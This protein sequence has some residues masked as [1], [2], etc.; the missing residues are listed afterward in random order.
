MK[1]YGLRSVHLY[2]NKEDLCRAVEEHF[3]AQVGGGTSFGEGRW[4]VAWA[5]R[6]ARGAGN[7]EVCPQVLF[8]LD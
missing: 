5:A 3:A 1:A 8:S 2:S 7:P 6:S 4:V